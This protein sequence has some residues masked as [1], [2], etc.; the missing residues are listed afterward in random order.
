MPDP[1]DVE[2]VDHVLLEELQLTIDLMAAANQSD[3]SLSLTQID[4]ILGV[5]G[6][7]PA[8]A[9]AS[10]PVGTGGDP[11]AAPSQVGQVH[12]PRPRGSTG[13]AGQA[14]EDDTVAT[15]QE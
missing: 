13:T 8:Q 11:G 2:L 7:P 6:S 9:H 14:P 12:V 1:F 5:T 15:A 4:R 10:E 3:A